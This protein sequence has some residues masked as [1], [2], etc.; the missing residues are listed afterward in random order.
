MSNND[1]LLIDAPGLQHWLEP[2]EKL[3]AGL[4][5][6]VHRA[7]SIEIDGVLPVASL[8]GLEHAS[9]AALTAL[10]DQAE[11]HPDEHW[12][13]FDPVYLMPDLTAVWIHSRADLDLLKG[14]MQPLIDELSIMFEAVGLD[15][16]IGAPGHYG[17]IR[18]QQ[19]IDCHFES[20]DQV[21]GRRLDEVLP[22]GKQQLRWRNLLNESQMIFHQFRAL[23]DAT[24]Q[25]LGLWFW[26]AGC[27]PKTRPACSGQ[28]M[29]S[30]SG[31]P[32]SAV[33]RGLAQWTQFELCD[34]H[35]FT[36]QAGVQLVQ[37]QPLRTEPELEALER[38]WIQPAMHALAKGHLRQIDLLDQQRCWRMRRWDRWAFWRK[39]D[40]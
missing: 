23:D 9:P 10:A 37:A 33:W 39:A 26:G 28:I 19:P 4:G 27:L 17:L 7:K 32:I 29:S 25:S 31:G 6:F 40:Q 8:L 34:Q 35:S 3:P 11:P 13:R 22:V 14:A 21:A 1:Q 16:Q 36:P 2:P 38:D 15:W 20:L 5:L 24:P 18:S 12:L 30:S